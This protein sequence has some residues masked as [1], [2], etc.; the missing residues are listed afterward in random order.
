VLV[1]P[2]RIC[3][4]TRIE[5]L[6]CNCTLEMN[7]LLPVFES[8]TKDNCLRQMVNNRR[9]KSRQNVGINCTL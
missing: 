8:L 6:P 5:L 2:I 3:L 7:I 1:L 9:M 4:M